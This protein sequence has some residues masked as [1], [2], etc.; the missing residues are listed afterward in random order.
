MLTQQV[1]DHLRHLTKERTQGRLEVVRIEQ[2]EP[3]HGSKN[4]C[5]LEI[6]YADD[7]QKSD[8]KLKRFAKFDWPV[9]QNV[10]LVAELVNR[11]PELIDAAEKWLNTEG[12][13]DLFSNVEQFAGSHVLA[14]ASVDTYSYDVILRNGW[15][16]T[17]SSVERRGEWVFCSGVDKV[18]EGT[19]TFAAGKYARG[20][21]VRFSE[22]V[23]V[24]DHES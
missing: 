9:I 4:S 22:I 13:V 11:A 12:I 14:K 6:R 16:V 17:C 19:V 5:E 24:V 10:E 15:T 7:G 1:I 21:E 3:D 8:W 2:P 20:I 23:A 18:R